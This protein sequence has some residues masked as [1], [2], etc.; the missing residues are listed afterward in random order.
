VPN[1]TCYGLDEGAVQD[2]QTLVTAL[3][4]PYP[5]QPDV[6]YLIPNDPVHSTVS[7][8]YIADEPD[9][10]CDASL[11]DS[12]EYILIT[13]PDGGQQV[14]IPEPSA[15]NP[16]LLMAISTIRQNADT[17]NFPLATIVTV[18]YNSDMPY[19]M[20]LFD[21]VGMDDYSSV[22][23]TYL[24]D[25][26]TFETITG[27]QGFRNPAAGGTPQHFFLVPLVSMGI[28]SIGVYSNSV[29]IK[30]RFNSDSNLIGIMPF[31]WSAASDTNGMNATSSWAPGYI[32]LGTSIVAANAPLLPPPPPPPV[33]I[34]TAESLVVIT[35]TF[36]LQ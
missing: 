35:S 16:A 10:S 17:S 21:W 13:P 19:G 23:P 3:E 34:S 28:D 32:A 15:P 8:F 5:D 1:N 18:G 29:P 2:F 4:H 14:Y 36:L 26:T 22:V 33:Q 9:R 7:S 30:N 20:S 25:F 12:I 6:H 24:D 11:A 31:K 27:F